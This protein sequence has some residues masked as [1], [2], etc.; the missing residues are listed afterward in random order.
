MKNAIE[1]AIEGGYPAPKGKYYNKDK[2]L[3]GWW[4]KWKSEDEDGNEIKLENPCCFD[5]IT[6]QYIF[7]M[8]PLFWQALGCNQGWG[9][10]DEECDEN[11][12]KDYWHRFIDHIADGGDI[13]EYF[14]QILK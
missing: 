1:K 10:G 6:Y 2:T 11:V 3:G 4:Y 5:H 7:L 9:V 13:D 12:W 8:N 14:N